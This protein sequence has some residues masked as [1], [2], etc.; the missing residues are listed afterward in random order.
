M[1]P[2]AIL[3]AALALAGC[4]TTAKVR[5]KLA[6]VIAVKD[7][8]KPASVDTVTAGESLPIPAG[9]RLTLT[10]VSALPFIPATVSAPEQAAQPA[11][12][13]TQVELAGP[14]VWTRDAET[15]SAQSGTIDQ[16][17][18]LRKVEAAE[19]RV[20]LY[21]ALAC[22]VGAGVFFWAHYPTPA[23][24]CAGAS[25]VCFAAWKVSGLPS[26]FWAV[27]VAAVGIGAGLYFGFERA[28]KTIKPSPTP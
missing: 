19:S 23:L 26:W 9:S 8:G 5:T 22:L 10:K 7:A 1:R 27:A 2:A 25:G 3:L 16:S 11:R 12:E 18:A 17:V 20:L 4:Q 14:S 28:S 24:L 6:E 13:V 21:A 15:V